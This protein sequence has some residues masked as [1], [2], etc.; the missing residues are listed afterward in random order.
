MCGIAGFITTQPPSNAAVVLA[1]MTDVLAHRGP[2]GRGLWNDETAWLG[3]RRLSIIDLA[4]GAQPM[5]DSSESSWIVYNGEIYN[6]AELRPDL[7]RAGRRYRTRCDTET[8]LHAYA[9]HGPSCVEL[10]RGMFAFAIWD[11]QARTLFCARDRLGI[12]PLYYWTDGA[13]F[14]LSSEIKALL[15][16]PAVG[17]EL[18]DTL[19]AEHLAFGFSADE[20]TLFRGIRQLPPGHTLTIRPGGKPE[21]RRYWDALPAERFEQ[22]PEEEWV[23]ECRAGFELSVR[24]RL[25]SDVPLGMFLSGGVDSSAVAAVLKGIA[26]GPVKTYSVGY[27]EQQYSELDY[28][29]QTAR[30]IGTA[31]REVR[32]GSDEFFDALP[33]LVWHEDK[34]LAW[35]SSISLHFVSRLAAEEVKV[36][37]TG[38]GA[39]ELFAGYGRYRHYLAGQKFAKSYGVL[40]EALRRSIRGFVENSS[41]LSA[42][43]RRK[44]GHTILGREAIVESLYLDN[45]LGAFSAN[46][47]VGL[48]RRDGGSPYASF[49]EHWN[50]AGDAPLLP[51]LLYADQKTYLVELL[52]KQDRMSMSASLESRVP[53]LDHSFVEQAARV[54][55]SLKLRGRT[56]KYLF[57]K[58]VEGL[59]PEGIIHRSKMGFPTPWKSWIGEKQ[60]LAEIRSMLLARDGLLAEHLNLAA[61]DRLLGAHAAGRIDAADRI[62]RLVNLQTWGEVFLKGRGPL[63]WSELLAGLER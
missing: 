21:I 4:A 11:R 30:A 26:D 18:D 59:I 38:E 3:H 27:A 17:L 31:H 49:L 45:F 50:R 34:P 63:N 14:V 19:I 20:R 56:G 54:P 22:K 41:L 47:Q 32:L 8:I 35:P 43:L 33:R 39:D 48:L 57:K 23:R 1:E 55:D 12:K 46:E 2:D 29:A 36:V 52:M 51:R 58:V 6:H 37:L 7:E 5:S 42:D 24:Q 9:E 53:F 10:F 60:R 25:M 28:A 40:P 13:S 16:H 15:K 62:W 61:V 44:L